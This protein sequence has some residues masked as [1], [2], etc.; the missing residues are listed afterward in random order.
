MAR[1]FDIVGKI[2]IRLRIYWISETVAKIAV[3]FGI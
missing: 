2:G 1:D 3:L